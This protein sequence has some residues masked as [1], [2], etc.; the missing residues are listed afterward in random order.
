MNGLGTRTVSYLS[1]LSLSPR[2]PPKGLALAPW[3]HSLNVFPPKCSV[4]LK[5]QPLFMEVFFLTAV[6]GRS[7]VVVA[8]HSVCIQ[9]DTIVVFRVA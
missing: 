2:P 8:P 9:V 5:V 6:S 3:R 4:T 7:S 1:A